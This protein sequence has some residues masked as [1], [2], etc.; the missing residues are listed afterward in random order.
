[1]A[2]QYSLAA[3]GLVRAEEAAFGS[4]VTADGLQRRDQESL[5]GAVAHA[6]AVAQRRADALNV[7][8]GQDQ[9]FEG[10]QVEPCHRGSARSSLQS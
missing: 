9:Y 3:V 6:Q 1:M 2:Q 8:R 10:F 4:S 7:V 5:H